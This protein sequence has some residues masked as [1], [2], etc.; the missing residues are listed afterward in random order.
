MSY[1]AFQSRTADLNFRNVTLYL[2][3]VAQLNADSAS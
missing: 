1:D 2:A 3:I